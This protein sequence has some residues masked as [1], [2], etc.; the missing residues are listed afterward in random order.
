MVQAATQTTR[1]KIH[2]LKFATLGAILAGAVLL[3]TLPSHLAAQGGVDPNIATDNDF[4]KQGA[5]PIQDG[6]TEGIANNPVVGAVNA[7]AAHPSN[8][9]ILYLGAVNGGI[10]RTTNATATPP[11]W[12][13]L[14][15]SASSLSIG[16]IPHL[17][18]HFGR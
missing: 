8:S 5:S 9:N 12:T 18:A 14:T 13:P 4:I 2:T 7:L 10:W 6:Q 1:S 16:T 15:E 17:K 3:A 11:T